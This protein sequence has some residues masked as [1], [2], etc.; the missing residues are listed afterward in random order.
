MSSGSSK[1]RRDPTLRRSSGSLRVA[2][3]SLYLCIRRVRRKFSEGGASARTRLSRASELSLSKTVQ[4]SS[5]QGSNKSLWQHAI[6]TSKKIRPGRRRTG[7]S[8]R[9]R[10]R[11]FFLVVHSAHT[12]HTAWTAARSRLFLF[13]NFGH[14]GFGREQ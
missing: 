3:Q 11:F 4:T 13:R 7:Y 5:R 9:H 6:P 2:R 1:S 12:A 14:Q 8:M 10:P